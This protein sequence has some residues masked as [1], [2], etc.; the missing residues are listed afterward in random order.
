MSALT[1]NLADELGPLGVTSVAIHPGGARTEKTQPEQEHRIAQSNTIGRIVD[2]TEIAWLVT[3]L[4][5][6]KSGAI[7]GETIA[8]GGGTP[9]VINY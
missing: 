1:K 8:A 3:V 7:N 6:P 9:K 5:S 4:A 2:A